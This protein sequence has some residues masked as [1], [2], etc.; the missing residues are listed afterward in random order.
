MGNDNDKDGNGDRR[1]AQG[2]RE[3]IISNEIVRNPNVHFGSLP[4]RT[5]KQLEKSDC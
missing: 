3:A 4:V 2:L 5:A 1:A